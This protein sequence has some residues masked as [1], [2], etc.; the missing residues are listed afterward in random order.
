MESDLGSAMG[1]RLCQ[2][3]RLENPIL[4]ASWPG[5]GN[6][7]MIAVDTSS[8]MLGGRVTGTNLALGALCEGRRLSLA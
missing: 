3:P 6:S 8:G 2:E 1:I 5:I 4:V 7:G